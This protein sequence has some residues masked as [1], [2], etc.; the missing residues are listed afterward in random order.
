[1]PRPVCLRGAVQPVTPFLAV[2]DQNSDGAL[3]P[4]T[5]SAG[6]RYCLGDRS[7]RFSCRRP[8]S[9]DRL[10]S[11]RYYRTRDHKSQAEGARS[12]GMRQAKVQ[13]R[14]R[15][16]TTPTAAAVSSTTDRPRRSAVGLPG[17]R[18]AATQS[19]RGRR[20]VLVSRPP[21]RPAPQT[22]QSQPRIPRPAGRA[23][24]CQ[25]TSLRDA[26][27]VLKRRTAILAEI[28][29]LLRSRTH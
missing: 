24:L 27:H 7:G 26:V 4:A 25:H 2:H 1:V 16:P 21:N 5:R 22:P 18:P 29:E 17:A 10:P 12:G 3:T 9:C 19:S 13:G 14:Q 20:P 15:S 6:R 28:L 8:H 23:R 11:P